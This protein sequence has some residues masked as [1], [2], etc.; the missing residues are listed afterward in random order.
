MSITSLPPGSNV[1][2]FPVE[3]VGRPTLEL[4]RDLAPDVRTVEMMA[5][6][7]DLDVPAPEFRDQVDAEAAEYMLNHMI[8]E[9]GARRAQQLAEMQEPLVKAAVEASC[10]SRRAFGLV[11]ELQ[12]HVNRAKVQGGFWL[13]PIEERLEVRERQAAEAT[14]E[15]HLRAEEAE[16]VARAVSLARSG[17]PWTPRSVAADMDALLAYEVRQRA[18]V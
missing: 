18:V 15:A 12:E 14:I 6:A 16:G 4:M 7:Y 10:A 8:P 11:E 2:R 17:Q 5:E 1:V 9:P 3:L 13:Q